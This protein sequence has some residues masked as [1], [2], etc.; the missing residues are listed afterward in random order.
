MPSCTNTTSVLYPKIR[1]LTMKK[2]LI[3]SPII[4]RENRVHRRA[5]PVRRATT[6]SITARPGNRLNAR[7]QTI[8]S[9]GFPKE[10]LHG[11]KIV[12]ESIW[13]LNT[14]HCPVTLTLELVFTSSGTLFDPNRPPRVSKEPRPPV[15][16]P[17]GHRHPCRRTGDLPLP[18]QEP[19]RPVHR[20]LRLPQPAQAAKT[21]RAVPVRQRRPT[22]LPLGLGIGSTPVHTRPRSN[23]LRQHLLPAVHW[24]HPLRLRGPARRP[25]AH[26]LRTHRPLPR[27]HRRGHKRHKPLAHRRQPRTSSVASSGSPAKPK[28]KTPMSISSSHRFFA[29]PGY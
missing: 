17:R 13:R 29:R 4:I 24:R 14:A 5:V 10:F 27:V 21:G 12:A 20:P 16:H 1:S 26:L 23:P 2:S 3:R 9:L 22:R 28:S 7:P 18:V 11:T 15:G 19:L 6:N 25:S 8:M